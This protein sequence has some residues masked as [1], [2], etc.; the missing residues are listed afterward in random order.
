LATHGWLNPASKNW[1]ANFGKA[2]W[3]HK[4]NRP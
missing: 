2:V 4:P 3:R 1:L